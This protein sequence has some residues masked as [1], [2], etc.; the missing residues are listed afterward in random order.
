MPTEESMD[1]ILPLNQVQILKMQR[2]RLEKLQEKSKKPILIKIKEGEAPDGTSG[3]GFKTYTWNYFGDVWNKAIDPIYT[4]AILRNELLLDP[5]LKEWRR[6]KA[7]MTKVV[8]F[9]KREG[10][11]MELAYTGGNG[12]HGDIFFDDIMIDNENLE[13]AKTYDID[14]FKV[15]RNTLVEFILEGAGT[16]RRALA[17]DPKKINF[18]KLRLGSQVREYGTMRR[19]KDDRIIE[20]SYKTL[21]SEMP[22]E[23]PHPGSLPLAFPEKVDLWKVPDRYNRRIN[24]AI[25]D[26]LEKSEHRSEYNT[27][28]ADLSGSQLEKI[29]CIKRLFRTGVPPGKRY[30]GAGSIALAAKKCGYSWKAAE[31]A[32]KKFF[33]TCDITPSEAQLRTT[34]CKMLFEGDYHFSCKVVKQTFGTDLCESKNCIVREKIEKLKREAE[35]A[36]NEER[37]PQHIIDRANELLDEG[38]ALYFI[39]DTAARLHVGDKITIKA[40]FAAIAGQS[41][42]NSHG[43]QPKVSGGSGKGKSHAFIVVIHLVP[44]EFVKAASLSA[45]APFY[46]NLK[47]GMIIFSD[48]VDP[49]ENIQAVIKRST[50]N[51][52]R[53][54][55]HEIPVKV[56]DA[57]TTRAFIIPPRIIWCLTSVN[58]NVSMEYLN[59]QFN[60]GVDESPEQDKEVWNF[61]AKQA[62]E[63]QPDLPMN[64]DIL[65]CREIIRDIKKHLFAVKVPFSDRI[66]WRN[67]ENRR[68]GAQFLDFIMSF[69][70]FNYR[71]RSKEDNNTIIANEDDFHQA[72]SLYGSR[73]PN[74]KFKLNDQ[75]LKVLKVM[76]PKKPYYLEDLQNLTGLSHDTVYRLFH[77]RDKKSGLMEKVPELKCMPET[78]YLG[79]I[80]YIETPSGYEYEKKI[81]RKS[82]PRNVFA[83]ETD[84]N[85]LLNFDKIAELVPEPGNP[86]AV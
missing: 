69:A 20:G 35:K 40:T 79:D 6:L 85:S 60:L 65:V 12:V 10:I 52:Q 38:K 46:S 41:V 61:L 2:E 78:E 56:G 37:V 80:D 63:A 36:K 71:I 3:E 48:D 50:T 26:E 64:D 33:S 67:P 75:E 51:F 83:L 42:I 62:K 9:C 16:N 22:D 4:R 86:Q 7:E 53:E 47:P 30:Y 17:L 13:K 28:N 66:V 74:Q 55:S 59:R 76:Q 84:F 19:D 29:P 44:A 18:D 27:E 8:D 25:R 68:N 11:P 57:W 70:V 82:R 39:M 1:D 23:R 24:E 34:N 5:D 15:V 43:I 14:L 54:T 21:I 72:V 58:D 81:I 32:I 45:K 31:D 73:A 49:D 77:G